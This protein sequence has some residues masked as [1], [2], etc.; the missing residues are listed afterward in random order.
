MLLLKYPYNTFC[1]CS[2][3]IEQSYVIILHTYMPLQY[4]GTVG[5][6]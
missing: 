6:V 3:L 4:V 1:R 2:I 5:S